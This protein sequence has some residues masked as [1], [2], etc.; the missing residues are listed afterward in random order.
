MDVSAWLTELG[1]ER[2][3]AAFEE[4]GVDAALLSELTNE[5]LKDLGIARIAD[6][7]RCSRPSRSSLEPTA[8]RS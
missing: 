6:R 5:D 1:L 8:R 3:A 2:Y 7:K 4:N